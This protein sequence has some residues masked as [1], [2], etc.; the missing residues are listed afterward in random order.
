LDPQVR[1]AAI[2]CGCLV[3]LT[4]VW[5]VW[6]RSNVSS[7]AAAAQNSSRVSSPGLAPVPV[8]GG[9]VSSGLGANDQPA[10]V[11]VVGAPSV[12]APAAAPTGRVSTGLG[13]NDQPAGVPQ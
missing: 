4:V 10:G 6:Y 3:A 8:P 7:P 2:V 9:A 13:Q 12:A 11:P 1:I 5:A